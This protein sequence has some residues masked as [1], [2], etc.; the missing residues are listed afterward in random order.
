MIQSKIC[1]WLF[2]VCLFWSLLIGDSKL[3]YGQ[4][5]PPMFTPNPPVSGEPIIYRVFFFSCPV[6]YT[7][8]AEGQRFWVE[9]N[10][11]DIH[12]FTVVRFFPCGT[13]PDPL[14]TSEFNLGPLAAGDYTLHQYW[15]S[16]ATMF[17]LNPDDFNP[18]SEIE[19][20]VGVGP[21]PVPSLNDI[22]IM[23]LVILLFG[24]AGWRFSTRSIG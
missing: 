15:V 24:V 11:Q 21:R 10:E 8:N 4:S 17:P 20:T 3:A 12:L 16:E 5:L 18:V 14:F 6:V 2:G 13:P 22:G 7:Q 23:L 1:S 9:R 19:F